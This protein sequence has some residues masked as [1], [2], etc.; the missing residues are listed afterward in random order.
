M[1][2]DRLGKDSDAHSQRI[3]SDSV[4]TDPPLDSDHP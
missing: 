4:I 3:T 1:H 2:Y